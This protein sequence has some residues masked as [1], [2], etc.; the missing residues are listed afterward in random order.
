MNWRAFLGVTT[1]CGVLATGCGRDRIG[2]P[3]SRGNKNSSHGQFEPPG[4]E[5]KAMEYTRANVRIVY[6]PDT[7]RYADRAVVIEDEA[8]L[9]RLLSFFPGIGQARKSDLAHGSDDAVVVSFT[10]SDGTTLKVS[11]DFDFWNEGC[12]DWEVSDPNAFRNYIGGLLKEDKT[13]E[14]H[15]DSKG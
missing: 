1:L 9:Q 14:K 3:D 6:D 11:S 10:K 2:P 15:G 4:T 13:P 12:G 8:E 7:A 5:R